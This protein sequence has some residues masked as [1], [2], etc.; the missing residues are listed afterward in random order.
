MDDKKACKA[1][2]NCLLTD[3]LDCTACAYNYVLKGKSG[4]LKCD[5]TNVCP[6]SCAGAAAIVNANGTVT[7]LTNGTTGNGSGSGAA[8]I[9]FNLFV[10]AFFAILGH[11]MI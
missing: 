1:D 10:L 8:N 2:A 11:M 9:A 3:G 6:A 4:C 5:D 7:A